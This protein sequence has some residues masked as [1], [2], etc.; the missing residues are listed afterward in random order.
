MAIQDAL[1]ELN[2][3]QIRLETS[4]TLSVPSKVPTTTVVMVEEP[5]SPLPDA[6]FP[7]ECPAP[8]HPR[9]PRSHRPALPAIDTSIKPL[10]Q[11]PSSAQ[12]SALPTAQTADP[13][14][15][16]PRSRR[17]AK[18]I[19][20][21]T[22]LLQAKIGTGLP[23]LKHNIYRSTSSG[24][25]IV[26]SASAFFTTD[27]FE[28]DARR[29]TSA[30]TPRR[31]FDRVSS[32]PAFTSSGWVVVQEADTPRPNR[33]RP[34]VVPAPDDDDD[35]LEADL[36]T[37]LH[38]QLPRG[39]VSFDSTVETS[40]VVD[41]RKSS[42]SSYTSSLKPQTPPAPPS[43]F[44]GSERKDPSQPMS[45]KL[46]AFSRSISVLASSSKGNLSNLSNHVEPDGVPPTSVRLLRVE[47]A[48]DIL[49]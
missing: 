33:V 36:A 45:S 30:R 29:S 14:P 24:R 42:F 40:S 17:I 4:K 23:K 35:D 38:T 49:Y 15:S 18:D 9:P 25:A 3:L 39:R 22:R 5:S 46:S 37:Q 20:E 7:S 34:P 16:I 13:S 6:P 44:R 8:S 1:S 19:N 43:S 48:V 12:P 31:S 21:K 2:V 26:S 11:P 32:G 27:K 28:K 10:P 47:G 41:S